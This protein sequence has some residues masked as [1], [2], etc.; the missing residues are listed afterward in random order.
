MTFLELCQRAAVE[1]GASSKQNIAI[2]MP[3]VV[4]ATGALARIINWVA[5]GFSDIQQDHSDWAWMRSSGETGGGASFATINGQSRYP[6]GT[7]AGTVGVLATDFGKWDVET[8]RAYTTTVGTQDEN[9]V[10]EIPYDRWRN[11]YMF[12]A[13]R[14]SRSRPYVA[15]VGPDLSLCLGPPPTGLY[16][17]TADYFRAPFDMAAD[18]DVPTG[19]PAQFH[20]LC[21]YRAMMKYAG[22]ESAPEVDTR[23]REENAGM[24]GQLEA[25]RLDKMTWAGA[26]A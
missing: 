10:Q 7:G 2:A 14:Q 5:D 19:L 25:L 1:C 8:F 15:A 20:M 4:G 11:G 6:L 16:T 21:V 26:L 13:M 18:A 3:T 12:G 23:A 9:Y 24:Y 17:V 22:Y